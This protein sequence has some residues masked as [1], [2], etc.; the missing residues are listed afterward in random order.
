M[1]ERTVQ[2]GIKTEEKLKGQVYSPTDQE[3]IRLLAK[4]R[5]EQKAELE[6]EDLEGYELPPRTQFSMLKKPAV[7]IKYGRMTF[8]MASIR[9]FEDI[10]YI[11]PLVHVEKKKLTIVMCSE[12][13][14]SSVAW[15]R[16]R[17]KDGQWVNKDITSEDFLEKIYKMMDWRRDC[18]YKVMGKVSNSQEGLVL[19]FELQEAIMFAPN[20]MEYKDN[21]TGEIKKKQVKYYPDVYKDR[22]GK[23]YNDYVATKQITLFEYLDEYSGKTYSDV[24][25]ESLEEA[26]HEDLESNVISDDSEIT[27]VL[28]AQSNMM[29]SDQ[30][31]R[32]GNVSADKWDQ[33]NGSGNR[34][35]T[36]RNW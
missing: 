3:L 11:L 18:R 8:N 31:N 29:A 15:A 13:E 2:Q 6:Y 22:I 16:K 34:G 14:A 5:K 17:V 24:P 7:S 23:S 30:E 36:E 21:V 1:E 19:V 32:S 33:T 28:S 27:S 25:E 26:E 35:N 9:M 4:S 12:E 10:E 20:P